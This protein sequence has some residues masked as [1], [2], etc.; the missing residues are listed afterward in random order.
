M[1]SILGSLLSALNYPT[2]AAALEEHYQLLGTHEKDPVKKE[3][4]LW[5]TGLF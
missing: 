4:A 3:K 2:R 1:V 5:R